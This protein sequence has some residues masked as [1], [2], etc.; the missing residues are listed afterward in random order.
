MSTS[1]KKGLFLLLSSILIISICYLYIDRSFAFWSYHQNFS[2]YPVF[3]NF[4][5]VIEF[6]FAFF[7]LFYLYF[8]IKLFYK[9][10]NLFDQK[11]L[12]IANSL[13]IT[14]LINQQLKFIFGRYWP[15]T[16]IHGNPSLIT[17][18]A[19]GFNFFHSDNWYGSF[20]SGHSAYTFTI[21]VTLWII[22]PRLRILA[23]CL[24]F[25]TIIGQL[26]MNYHFVSDVVAGS[27]L[28]TLIAYCTA[29]YSL[30]NLS[31]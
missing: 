24:P 1:L 22:F 19:Y 5:H 25:F 15:Q 21:A 9:R 7:T 14:F 8:A 31:E 20:P 29:N 26:T 6:L 10:I 23:V 13:A 17:D 4:T 12:I 28:G 3:K 30:K 18:N 11:L 16:W 27:M 2:Q